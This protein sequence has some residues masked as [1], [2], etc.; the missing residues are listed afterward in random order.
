MKTRWIAGSVT[1]LVTISVVVYFIVQKKVDLSSGQLVVESMEQA[2]KVLA[3]QEMT[4]QSQIQTLELKLEKADS[5]QKRQDKYDESL[6]AESSLD[7]DF[8]ALEQ[9]LAVLP[10]GQKLLDPDSGD[11]TY[12]VNEPVSK[13]HTAEWQQI[14]NEFATATGDSTQS[15]EQLFI[16]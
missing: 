11:A 14:M 2:E 9:R 5:R 4:L 3:K 16:D 13:R 15:L 6:L 10:S 12:I 1:V 8:A 7:A